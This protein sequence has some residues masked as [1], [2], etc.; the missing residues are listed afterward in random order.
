MA[1]ERRGA[2]S[3]IESVVLSDENPTFL[4]RIEKNENR[5]LQLHD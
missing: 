5:A 4:P 1:G 3:E 2:K